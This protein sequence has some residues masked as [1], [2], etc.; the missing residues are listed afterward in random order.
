MFV[1][2]MCKALIIRASSKLLFTSGF[3]NHFGPDSPADW[4]ICISHVFVTSL[5]SSSSSSSSSF[6]KSLLHC[7]YKSSFTFYQS[8]PCPSSLVSTTSVSLTLCHPFLSL[9]FPGTQDI[10]FLYLCMCMLYMNEIFK[11]GNGKK[12]IC[13][14]SPLQI[15]ISHTYTHTEMVE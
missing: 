3:T 5:L 12:A 10:S 11:Y 2:A 15:S 9:I 6:S 7:S 14:I 13:C 8:N 4:H 1:I